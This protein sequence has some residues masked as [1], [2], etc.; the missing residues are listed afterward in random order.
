M[1]GLGVGAGLVT[2]VGDRAALA[3]HA[4]HVTA[5]MLR[6]RGDPLIS[7]DLRASAAVIGPAAGCGDA[8]M[9]DV[10][11]LAR[12]GLPLVIDADGLTVFEDN[13]ARLFSDLHAAVILTPHA[14]EFG[15]LFPDISLEDR[16]RAAQQAASVSGAIIIL[17]GAQS[18]VAS[19]DGRYG[20][21]RH[22]AVWLATAGSGDVL[23]GMIGGL[24]AMGR[25][26]L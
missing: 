25:R 5:I 26:P 8:I 9:A 14:G 6:E 15:R 1:A 22:A 12:S 21:N 4:A 16:V 18:V 13:P 20:V 3:E 10:S 7:S 19:P 23:A 11:A 24:L 17:K 2:I